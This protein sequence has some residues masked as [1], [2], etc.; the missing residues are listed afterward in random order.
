MKSLPIL[1]VLMLTLWACNS[2]SE[3]E[4]AKHWTYEGETGPEHWAELEKNSQ[5][6][7]NFQS[8]INLVNYK[9]NASL[10]P[11][12]LHYAEQT[13][14]HDVV[15]NGHS[16]QYDFE[17]GD[18]L[19]WEKDTFNLTQ[20]H[21]H[22]P[23]EHLIDGV[24][25]PLEIHLVHQNK[26]NQFV[27]LAIMA[28]EGENSEPFEFLESYLPIAVGEQ[29]IIDQAFDIALNLPED[30]NYFHYKGSLTT[31]P[32][33]ESVNWL[34]FQEPIRVSLEQVMQL[35]Y[36]MPLNNYREEQPQHGRQIYATN[37]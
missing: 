32:C 7:G 8:P 24:R 12:N 16:I 30:R 33:T 35:K 28:K 20:F 18:F 25:Y 36:A 2:N 10:K 3:K 14:L 31:P 26:D 13:K 21:F 19:V 11:L 15:N 6:D 23:A 27:V 22:E 37:F 5:C 9:T 29:K 34:V 1:L 4:K 17:P